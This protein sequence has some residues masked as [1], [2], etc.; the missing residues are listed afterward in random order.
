[1]LEE[2]FPF[3]MLQT[4][5]SNIFQIEVMSKEI[6]SEYRCRACGQEFGSL[7]DMQKH[8]LVEHHQRGDIV[9]EPRE[10]E[11]A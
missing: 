2:Q 9:E 3:S 1:M 8:I 7:G 11:A 6:P 5:N 10:S 4:V